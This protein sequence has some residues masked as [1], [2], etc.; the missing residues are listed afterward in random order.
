[1]TILIDGDPDYMINFDKARPDSSYYIELSSPGY[2]G[3]NTPEVEAARSIG[4]R[5][6]WAKDEVR[7]ANASALMSELRKSGKI[8]P[9]YTPERN[10]KISATKL[11]RRLQKGEMK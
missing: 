7:R 2:G 11:S 3:P 9:I 6:S 4:K 8:K 5:E 10:A 1:M